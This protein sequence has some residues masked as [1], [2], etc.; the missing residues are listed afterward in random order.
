MGLIYREMP[1]LASLDI[2]K[3]LMRGRATESLVAWAAINL[4][5]QTMSCL[6]ICAC[7]ETVYCLCY[8]TP[9]VVRQ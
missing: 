4:V 9:C 3:P 7:R 1:W 8:A 2:I 5:S 6:D